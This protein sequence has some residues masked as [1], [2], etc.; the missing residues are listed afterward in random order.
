MSAYNECLSYPLNSPL[1]GD[2]TTPNNNGVYQNNITGSSSVNDPAQIVDN[3]MGT[4]S[5]FNRAW[6][7][8]NNGF[9]QINYSIGNYEK[10]EYAVGAYMLYARNDVYNVQAPRDWDFLGSNNGTD[11]TV[12][13]TFNN[14]RPARGETIFREFDNRQEFSLY[15]LRYYS[16]NGNTHATAI[17][18]WEM[19]ESLVRITTNL[20]VE[21][22]NKYETKSLIESEEN[23]IKYKLFVNDSQV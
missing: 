21:Y 17:G 5:S 18:E 7:N 2:I 6:I 1:R 23:K 8:G 14:W 9:F 4:V 10:K 13:D 3:R 11:W 15:R 20:S 22:N 16:N 19:W 12:L